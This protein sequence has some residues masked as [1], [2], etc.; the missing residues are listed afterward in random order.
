MSRKLALSLLRVDAEC[1]P[2]FSLESFH[3][4]VS[5]I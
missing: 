3:L 4:T 2:R 5:V 1:V